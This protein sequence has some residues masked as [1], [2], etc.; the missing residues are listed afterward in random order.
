MSIGLHESLQGYRVAQSLR[1]KAESYLRS[2]KVSD[3]EQG[4]T[5]E[6]IATDI[7]NDDLEAACVRFDALHPNIRSSLP[8]HVL[9]FLDKAEH[10][11]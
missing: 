6:N 3:V 10:G 2:N 1:K 5:L 9:D 8:F 4:K 11:V 7:I